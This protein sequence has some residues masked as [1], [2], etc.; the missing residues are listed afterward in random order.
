[1]KQIMCPHCGKP[2]ELDGNTYDSI[3]A[4]VKTAEFNEELHNRL[5]EL[6]KRSE[7]EI[8]LLKVQTEQQANEKLASLEK[9]YAEQLKIKENELNALK[10]E[11]KIKEV[12]NQSALELM[13]NKTMQ[14]YA[15]D[16]ANKEKEIVSLQARIK[17]FENEKT[18]SVKEAQDVI[19][20]ESLQTV[21]KLNEQINKMNLSIAKLENDIQLEQAKAE[22]KLSNQKQ[23]YEE[24]L[25]AEKELAESRIK[26]MQDEV[27]RVK[28]FKARQSTKAIGESLEVYCYN[29]FNK[30][31]SIAFPKAYFEKDNT[32]SKESGSKGDFIF[33]EWIDPETKENEL[34]SIM[35][36]M[37]NEAETTDVKARHT[38][39]SFL[40]ELDKDRKEK[41][42][43]YAVLVSTLEQDNDYYNQGIVD[44][45]YKYPKMFVVRPQFLIPLISTLTNAARSTIAIRN[46]LITIQNENRDYKHFEDNLMSFK[47]KLSKN[48]TNAQNNYSN[49]MA[50][51]DKAIAD[52]EKTREFLRKANSQYDTTLRIAESMDIPTLTKDAPSV[53]AQIN[54]TRVE[55]GEEEI[56]AKRTKKSNK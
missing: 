21:N 41:N 1:M 52:L 30:V 48:V 51:I 6:N 12:E 56:K 49:A 38:N 10:G 23:Q 46:E 39:E 19:R 42:C 44:M 2:I 25:A 9:K 54:E 43:E 55:R 32:V 35:F 5:E 14:E 40:K 28:D 22:S 18:L 17:A 7:S 20:N 26:I 24:K 4:Q 33:R 8:N 31:R 29:E 13:K 37:K 15:N 27:E 50:Q 36:E 47:D 11:V 3:V 53:L 34:I 16:L 45:S